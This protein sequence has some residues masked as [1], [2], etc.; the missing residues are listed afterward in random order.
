MLE[1]TNNPITFVY[2]LLALI[3]KLCL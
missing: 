2:V 1:N 3:T